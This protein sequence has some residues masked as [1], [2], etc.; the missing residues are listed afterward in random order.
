MTALAL[1]RPRRNEAKSKSALNTRSAARPE[2]SGAKSK[3]AATDVVQTPFDFAQDERAVS[4][5]P[6]Q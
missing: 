5:Q 4:G 6:A 3:G 2:R 1:A